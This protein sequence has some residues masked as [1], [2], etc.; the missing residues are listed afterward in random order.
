MALLPLVIDALHHRIESLQRCQRELAE[1]LVPVPGVLPGRRFGRAD[2]PAVWE[3]R[4]ARAAGVEAAAARRVQWAGDA[5]LQ[6]DVFLLDAWIGDG[7]R[8][9]QRLGVGMV[10]RRIDRLGRSALD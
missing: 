10:W 6:A 2:P 1:A 9:Q 7:H 4:A 3:Q 5:A 8:R